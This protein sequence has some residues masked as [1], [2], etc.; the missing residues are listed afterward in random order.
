MFN[1]IEIKGANEHN[2]KN[3]SINIPKHQL[4]EVRGPFMEI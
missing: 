4:V 1:Y 3:I 2:L